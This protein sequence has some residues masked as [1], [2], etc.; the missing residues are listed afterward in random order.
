[1]IDDR[2]RWSEGRARGRLETRARRGLRG[3]SAWCLSVCCVHGC[4]Q[5]RG[6]VDCWGAARESVMRGIENS[7]RGARRSRPAARSRQLIGSSAPLHC[8]RAGLVNQ[9]AKSTGGALALFFFAFL[10]SIHPCGFGGRNFGKA[11]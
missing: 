10:Y 6:V 7:G 9:T 5:G 8:T 4:Q 3:V 2:D 11:V 1:V